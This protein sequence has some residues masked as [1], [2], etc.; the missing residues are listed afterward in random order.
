MNE[1]PKVIGA[2]QWLKDL[3]EALRKLP[4]PT[5][6]QVRVQLEQVRAQLEAS[7]RIRRENAKCHIHQNYDMVNP[8]KINCYHCWH[9][10]FDKHQ[11]KEA[12]EL[13]WKALEAPE[14][15]VDN[16]VG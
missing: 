12:R 2:P 16:M 4:S 10:Y 5:V 15:L 13:F 6:E 3:M 8:P 9:A 11:T 1:M 7:A 14:G